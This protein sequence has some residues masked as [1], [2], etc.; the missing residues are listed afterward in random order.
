MA[1]PGPK[2]SPR[3]GNLFETILSAL[4]V[5]VAIGFAVFFFLQTGTGHFGSYSLRVSMSDASGL[6]IGSDVRL[7]GVKIGS[8]IGV[9][10]EQLS[11]RAVVEIKIRD[12][13]ALPVDSRASVSFSPFGDIYL[14]LV[15]GHQAKTIPRGGTMNLPGPARPKAD[16]VSL[17]RRHAG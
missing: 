6:S 4:V 7:A 11:H 17:G 10:F 8:V 2:V 1:L 5:L 3:G 16:Q 9:S 12:D 15:P 13:L 14:G